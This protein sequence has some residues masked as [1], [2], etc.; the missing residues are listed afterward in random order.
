MS[1]RSIVTFV[2]ERWGRACHHTVYVHHDGYPSHRGRQLMKFFKILTEELTDSRLNNAAKM[3]ARFVAFMMEEYR[4]DAVENNYRYR[5]HHLL[6]TSSVS[7]VE[8]D[9]LVGDAEY[10][11]VVPCKGRNEIPEVL[12]FH[13]DFRDEL[14]GTRDDNYIL[15]PEMVEEAEVLQEILDD[16]ED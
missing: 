5:D 3:A 12:M 16:L 8:V 4:R 10:M 6:G 13:G 1:T 2:D 11:Y 15:N 7:L 9:V 14:F